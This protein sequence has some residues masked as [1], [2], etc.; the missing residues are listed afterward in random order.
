MS[1]VKHT[2]WYCMDDSDPMNGFELAVTDRPPHDWAWVAEECAEDYWH[3]HDGWECSW[4]ATIHLRE[5]EEGPIVATFEVH[6]EAVPS[7]TAYEPK[8]ALDGG[9]GVQGAQKG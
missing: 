6:M 2:V 1:E 3:N 9:K 4:P 8:D 5:T 7:F